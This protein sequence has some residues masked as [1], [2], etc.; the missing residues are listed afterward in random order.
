MSEKSLSN[1]E[2]RYL[3]DLDK[4]LSDPFIET[5][6]QTART[7][8]EIFSSTIPDEGETDQIIRELDASWGTLIGEPV[9]LR[10]SS[11]VQT[12]NSNP[13]F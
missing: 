13:F 10:V 6:L 9:S 1:N 4:A 11:E 8:N 12:T 5:T 7:Y 2:S 3:N